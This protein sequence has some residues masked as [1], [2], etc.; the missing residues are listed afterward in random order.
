[1]YIYK[2][3]YEYVCMCT[4]QK[5]LCLSVLSSV[6]TAGEQRLDS[7]H[8]ETLLELLIHLTSVNPLLNEQCYISLQI[9]MA[10][11]HMET[12]LSV[13]NGLINSD[14]EKIFYDTVLCVVVCVGQ[15]FTEV[16][17]FVPQTRVSSR[18]NYCNQNWQFWLS[19]V[20]L[21]SSLE[22]TLINYSFLH[23]KQ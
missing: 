9:I 3:I 19:K 17:F 10:D 7:R 12:G 22:P 13:F 11:H 6:R 1:M 20:M 15:C 4:A 2:T 21:T 16:N 23:K 8:T 18:S 5:P 14:N